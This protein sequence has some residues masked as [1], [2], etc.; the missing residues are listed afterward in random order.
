MLIRTYIF[1]P[2][3]VRK[4]KAETSVYNIKLFFDK[5]KLCENKLW[6]KA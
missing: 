2:F 5:E 3:F 1:L 4:E 6:E